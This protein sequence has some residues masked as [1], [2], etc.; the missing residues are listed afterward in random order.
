MACITPSTWPSPPH[1]ATSYRPRLLPPTRFR[2]LKRLSASS[3]DGTPEAPDAVKLALAKA[4]AYKKSLTAKSNPTDPTGSSSKSGG[5]YSSPNVLAS[6]AE[7][8]RESSAE[9]LDSEGSGGDSGGPEVPASV[10]LAMER[11]REY[12]KETKSSGQEEM[13][14]NSKAE[15]VENKTNKKEAL[16]VSSTDFLGFGF[17][18]KK[19]YR[20]PPPGLMQ[21]VEPFFQG[22]APDVEFIVG[23]TSKFDVTT[24]SEISS[25]RVDDEVDLYKPKVSTWGVFPRPSNISKTFGGGKVIRPGEVQ[26]TAEER[27]AKDKRTKELIAAYKNKMGL[28]IDAKTKAECEKAQTS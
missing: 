4:A 13:A 24:P 28:T 27:A 12:N 9:G 14:R 8:S 15:A 23:D 25:D 6:A 26:E 5:D 1:R 22:D 3:A 11:A 18:D 21:S 17:S 10:K 16:K 2:S 19:R 20:G 7:K